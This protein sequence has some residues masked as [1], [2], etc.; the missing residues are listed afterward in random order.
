[1]D[2]VEVFQSEDNQWRF[3][4]VG[5][6][7]KIVAASEGYA[8]KA[9]ALR[10]AETLKRI[11]DGDEGL[12]RISEE[13]ARVIEKEQYTPEQD[14]GR[15]KELIAAARCYLAHAEGNMAFDHLLMIPKGWPWARVFWKPGT[16]ERDLEK[17]GALIAAALS[18]TVKE[19]EENRDNG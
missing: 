12:N 11:L 19:A 10:G 8:S 15:S 5:N 17:A 14:I 6:N 18:A 3:R 1:M 9:N 16:K 4:I 7:E 2:N 13:R